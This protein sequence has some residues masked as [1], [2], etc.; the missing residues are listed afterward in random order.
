MFRKI[1]KYE[2]TA[3]M[4]TMFPVYGAVLVI[5]LL[6]GIFLS[7]NPILERLPLA[8]YAKV[9]MMLLYIGGMIAM[10]VFTAVMVMQRFYKGLLR[11]EGYL[12]FTL[13]VKAWQLV[14]SKALAAFFMAVCATIAAVLS[15]GLLIGQDFFVTLGQLPGAIGQL[16][17]QALAYDKGAFAHMSIFAVE[18]GALCIAATF[19]G[20]YHLY[21]S[22]A[23]GHMSGTHK[24]AL[25]VVW[26]VVISAISNFISALMMGNISLLN[27][28]I[29]QIT[30]SYLP[31]HL[32]ALIPLAVELIK[33]A[34]FAVITDYILNKKLN[35]E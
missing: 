2:W 19:G 8:G 22:M 10:W 4:R 25:S 1:L 35:L 7:G 30:V 27:K 15:V 21:T 14:L 17:S 33:L 28:L 29:D 9:I 16:V 3:L 20:I 5:S 31:L 23:L 34:A 18:I 32:L 11:Q 26:Y 6:N 12:M 24:I 13:P